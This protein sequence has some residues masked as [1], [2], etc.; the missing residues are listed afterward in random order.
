LQTCD[1]VRV[2]LDDRRLVERFIRVPWYINRTH[3]PNRHWVPPLM[4]ER[5]AYLNAHRNPFFDHVDAAFWIA[6]AAGTD[7]GRIAAIRDLDWQHFHRDRAGSFGMFDVIRDPD[8]ASALLDKAISWL[9]ARTVEFVLGPFDLSTNYT[10]GV[11]VKGFELDPF[12]DMPYNPPY[13]DALLTGYGFRQEMDLWQW[14]IDPNKPV[15]ERITRLA[16]RVRQRRQITVRTLKLHDWDAE[17]ERLLSLYNDIWNDNWGFAPLREGEFHHIAN[18]MRILIREETALAVEINGELVAF[19]L[20]I[21]N[22]NPLLK[23][24]NG[25]LL[26]FGPPILL[27]NLRLRSRVDSLRFMLFGI[28]PQYRGLGIDSVLLVESLRAAARLRVRYAEAGWTSEDNFEINRAIVA[29]G[30]EWIKTYRVYRLDLAKRT[31]RQRGLGASS[32]QRDQQ[33]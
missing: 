14:R 29:M 24:L 16:N 33:S 17:L 27:W 31:D 20:A 9:R 32:R 30:G 28:R 15:P 3:S 7:V 1:I 26:P 18:N 11:L 5:R 2:S 22:I 8:V 12:I 23:V 21:P 19:S 4:H 10:T 25:R 6:R 13:Y